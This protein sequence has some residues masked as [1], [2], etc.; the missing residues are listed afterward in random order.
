MSGSTSGTPRSTAPALVAGATVALGL[1]S[2]VLALSTATSA[3]V[4]LEDNRANQWLG[5]LA[6]GLAGALVLRSQPGNR[7]GW[8]MAASG[9]G[10]SLG[11]TVTEY[12][13]LG[14]DHG[15]PGWQVA[16]WLASTVW[17]PSFLMVLAALPLLFPDGVLPS[18]RW[19]VP[20]LG[21]LSAGVLA[22]ITF[23]TT[24]VPLD[25]SGY[26]GVRNPLDLP[27]DDDVQ[28]V[29]TI[30]CFAVV[31]LVGA[32]AA[33]GIVWRMR[34]TDHQA[35]LQGAWFV[36][37]VAL[38]GF[39]SLLSAPDLVQFLLSAG[40][41]ACLAIG[42]VRYRLFAIDILLSRAVVYVVLTA[43]AL[44]AYLAAA[45]LLGASSDAG[46]VPAV[47]TAVVALLL[48]TG[49]QRL[50][51]WVDRAMYGQRRDPMAALAALGER[52]GSAVDDDQVLPAIVDGVRS[53]L[54]LPYAEVRLA[55]ETG[56]AATSGDRPSHTRRFELDHA[57]ER[58]GVLEVGVRRGEQTLSTADER[59]LEAFARQAGVAAHGVRATRELRRSRQRVV[60]SREE[61]RRRLRRELHD[62]LG[63]ALAGIS[64][65]LEQAEKVSHRDPDTTGALLAELRVDTTACVDEVRRIVADLRPPAL[66][67]SGLTEALR[68]HAELLTTRSNGAFTVVV[69]D[70]ALPDLPP[71][72]EVAAYRIV[73][74]AVTNVVRHAGA[75]TCT[76]ALS[77]SD[78]PGRAVHLR[79]S[80][81]GSGAPPD[82]SGNGLTTMRERA[83]ELGGTCTVTF[84]PGR[85]TTVEAVLPTLAGVT[86]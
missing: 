1:T 4:L 5:G 83:E 73:T 56:P 23:C 68:R 72:V 24:Q 79:V 13:A 42:I 38:G 19:R 39:G 16:A 18:R 64:L 31:A 58:V 26:T 62:G 82:G 27:F 71:A 14:Q 76:I 36:A 41:V 28:L 15:F 7:L 63:P 33:L 47:V 77:S 40:S 53:T 54:Q 37:S 48:A 11:S 9:L 65:G 84:R 67:Q 80:D 70:G 20:A 43:G 17:F 3:A 49:R 61:E 10:A 6:F 74:E 59:L 46:L 34:D 8:V 2:L 78:G 12:A 86:A 66:D 25:D 35:R 50:Q 81:D 52:L 55:G 51:R 32:A 69:E 57:G 85:G 44:I 45:A 21:A 30:A 60:L 22:T 29:V 75:T